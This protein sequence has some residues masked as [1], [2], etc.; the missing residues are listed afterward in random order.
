M[1]VLYLLGFTRQPSGAISII[2]HNLQPGICECYYDCHDL[3]FRLP[4]WIEP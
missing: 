2:L 3:S 1:V 4:V